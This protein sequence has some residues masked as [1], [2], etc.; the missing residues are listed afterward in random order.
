MNLDFFGV[1]FGNVCF[2][3]FLPGLL[4]VEPSIT[5]IKYSDKLCKNVNKI[6][7]GLCFMSWSGFEPL[8]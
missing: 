4:I 6:I 7:I 5:L 8:T 1:F 3:G 2:G